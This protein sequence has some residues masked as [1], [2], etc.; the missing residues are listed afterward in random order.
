MTWQAVYAGR[1]SVADNRIWLDAAFTEGM[2]RG[3][4]GVSSA[5]RLRLTTL[6]GQFN[7]ARHAD[8]VGPG[9]LGDDRKRTSAVP[10]LPGGPDQCNRHGTI[11]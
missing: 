5:G 10:S 4:D 1:R 7:A 8:E 3:H 2:R 11:C 6:T 9:G